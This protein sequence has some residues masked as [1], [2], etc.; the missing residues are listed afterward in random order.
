[1]SRRAFERVVLATITLLLVGC[2]LLGRDEER[3]ELDESELAIVVANGGLEDVSLVLE[4]PNGDTD[5]LPVQ[6]CASLVKLLST[7]VPWR[8]DVGEATVLSLGEVTILVGEPVS[9]Y[10]VI[11]APDGG[12]DVAGPEAADR[13]PEAGLR[14]PCAAR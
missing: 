6:P 10:N 2:G 8:L 4:Q 3:S 9:V 14:F 7:N 13:I 1:M 12:V 11:V 5:T